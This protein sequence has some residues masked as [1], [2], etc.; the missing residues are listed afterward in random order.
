LFNAISRVDKK[1]RISIP[2]GLRLKLRL[3]EGSN[4]KIVLNKKRLIVTPDSDD[5]DE[6][7]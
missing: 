6:N 2:V 7:V 1:G 4:V 3:L 5:G